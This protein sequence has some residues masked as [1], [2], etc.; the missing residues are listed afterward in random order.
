M[1]KQFVKGFAMLMLIV[2]LAFV[3]AVVSANGQS[4]QMRATVPFDFIVGDRTLASGRYDATTMNAAGN[5]LKI[6]DTAAKNAAVRM[7]MPLDGKSGNSKLVFH[8][9]GQ[10]YFLS[11][12]W[13][14]GGTRGRQVQ[15]SR[16][17]KALR[18][19]LSKIASLGSPATRETFETVEIAMVLN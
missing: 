1:R 7:T 6:S 3:T 16:Q 15:E 10:T 4:H 2:S 19:E 13:S 12:V 5:C 8:R 17:E 9:Y 18:K 11:E 14:G